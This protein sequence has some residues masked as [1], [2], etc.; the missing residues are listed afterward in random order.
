MIKIMDQTYKPSGKLKFTL[1]LSDLVESF[2][3]SQH[4][5]VVPLSIS[6]DTGLNYI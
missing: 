4:S 2:K 3:Q 1:P 6:L 5:D